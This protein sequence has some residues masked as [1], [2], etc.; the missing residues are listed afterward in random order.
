[1]RTQSYEELPH[2]A[3]SVVDTFD[4]SSSPLSSSHYLSE[5]RVSSTSTIAE[6]REEMLHLTEDAQNPISRKHQ[7]SG[8]ESQAQHDPIDLQLDS[9]IA[10]QRETQVQQMHQKT[11]QIQALEQVIR[12]AENLIQTLKSQVADLG[13]WNLE[14]ET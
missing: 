13:A 8:S 2:G 1:M 10:R 4:L 9:P 6:G 12:Q 3:Y 7:T 14:T 5:G 11:S